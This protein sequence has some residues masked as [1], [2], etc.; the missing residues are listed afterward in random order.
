M[1]TG[2]TTTHHSRS[3]IV[4]SAI[5]CIAL[6]ASLA[7]AIAASLPTPAKP[8]AATPTATQSPPAA[9]TSAIVVDNAGVLALLGEP[10]RSVKGE[11]LGKV[12]DL[13]VDHSGQI[14]AAI[15][16]FG[17]FL[18]VG[19]R[20]IAVDWRILHFPPG[21]L[22]KLIVDLPRDRLRDAPTYKAGEPIVIIGPAAPASSAES[23]KPTATLPAAP[24]SDT[25]APMSGI[26]K[27][28]P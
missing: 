26:P 10:V 2:T 5:V 23:P 9:E 14:L 21:A 8:A 7:H 28:T 17:G 18:G 16:D 15:V 12:V 24:G 19:S 3:P 13:V 27:P 4:A 25:P 6:V 1:T 22:D 20:K 11:D